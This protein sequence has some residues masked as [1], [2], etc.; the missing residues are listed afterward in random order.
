[1]SHELVFV[2]DGALTLTL[3]STQT[4]NLFGWPS[5]PRTTAA[6]YTHTL[7]H[8]LRSPPSDPPVVWTACASSETQLQFSFR[9]ATILFFLACIHAGRLSELFGTELFFG[10][11]SFLAWRAGITMAHNLYF[12]YQPRTSWS[13]CYVC[14]YTCYSHD[15]ISVADC[16]HGGRFFRST[17]SKLSLILLYL[18]QALGGDD[19]CGKR[20]AVFFILGSNFIPSLSRSRRLISCPWPKLWLEI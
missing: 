10:S 3:N 4:E 6:A 5:I 13:Q 12:A 17:L 2:S 16:V 18:H 8:R 19:E 20:T 1:M 7:N 11:E 9:V 15:I 14:T